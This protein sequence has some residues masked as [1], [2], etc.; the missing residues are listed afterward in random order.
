ML[1]LVTSSLPSETNSQETTVFVAL[2]LTPTGP[3][4]GTAAAS[5]MSWMGGATG[6]EAGS[7]YAVAQSAAMGGASTGLV[8]TVGGM[9]VGGLV[10][11]AA[12]PIA[13]GVAGAM[14]TGMM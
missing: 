3:A 4:A 11:T 12:L 14:Y 10:A 6:V 1:G 5:V 2:G 8:A 13:L 7:A 9:T